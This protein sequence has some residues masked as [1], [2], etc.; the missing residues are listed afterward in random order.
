ML[1]NQTSVKISCGRIG[2]SLLIDPTSRDWWLQGATTDFRFP[3]L[4]TEAIP[5]FQVRRC[6]VEVSKLPSESLAQLDSSAA[7]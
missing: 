4:S 3:L 7:R 6:D 2:D 5:A 1:S